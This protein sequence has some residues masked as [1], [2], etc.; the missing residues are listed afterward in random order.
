MYVL[1]IRL[2]SIKC[3]REMYCMENMHTDIKV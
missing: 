1:S 3:I 2:L